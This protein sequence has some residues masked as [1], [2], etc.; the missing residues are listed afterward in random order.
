MP[1]R[2]L[3]VEISRRALLL[4]LDRFLRQEGR[5]IRVD[6][7]GQGI[8][9]LLVDI[10]ANN[11]VAVDLDIEAYARERGLMEPWERLEDD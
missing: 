6:R 10:E 7:K 9:Y 3:T 2:P 5:R 1:K 4:R 8:R 11:L